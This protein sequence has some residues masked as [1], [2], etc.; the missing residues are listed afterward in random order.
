MD[1]TAHF[2]VHGD[3]GHIA[4]ALRSLYSTTSLA[5]RTIV[6]VNTGHDDRI[7]DLEREFPAI[8]FVIND[9]PRSFAANHNAIMRRADTPYVALLNDDL[10]FC[11]GAF[12]ALVAFLNENRTFGLAGPTLQNPDGTPQVSA[13]SDPS[14]LRTLYRISGLAT[15][16]SQDSR[17]RR[18]LLRSGALKRLNVESLRT[19]YETR[20]VDVVKGAAM[21]VR[22]EA[23]IQAGLMDEMTRAYGEEYG[24]HLR[25]RRAGWKLSLVRDS[26]IV[27][28]GRGQAILKIRGASLA[29]DRKAS[30]A[31]FLLYRPAWQ[32]MVVRVAMIVAHLAYAL[33]W[34]VFDRERADSHMT[35]ARMAGG[36]RR[37]RLAGGA[38]SDADSALSDHGSP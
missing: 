12:D 24:W 3:Y 28:H 23:Y 35:A 29:E 25:L 20:T 36:L 4:G 34:F 14:L 38:Q 2:I 27:H 8:E 13:Y 9:E 16:T 19:D 32:G 18:L 10:E 11:S 15:W 21:V 22:R 31:Y 5:I 33:V 7:A 30:L 37:E 17:V 26:R 6:T 1:V